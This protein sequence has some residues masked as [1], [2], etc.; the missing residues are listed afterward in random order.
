MNNFKIR[1]KA[2]NQTTGS[3]SGKP[4]KNRLQTGNQTTRILPGKSAKDSQYLKRIKKEIENQPDHPRNMGIA[5]QAHHVISGEGMKRSQLGPTV[6][7]YGYNINLLPNVAFIPCT[8]QGACYLGVQPHRGNHASK[9]VDQD[10]YIDSG[11]E[12]DYHDM[13]ASDL[14]RVIDKH[15]R[16]CTGDDNTVA[17][18]GIAVLDKL[19][20]SILKGIQHDPNNYPLTS[21]ASHF[22]KYGAGCGGVD[23]VTGHIP[24]MPCPVGRNHRVDPTGE[25][26]SHGKEQ[27]LENITF[28]VKSKY[29]LRFETKGILK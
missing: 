21:I 24:L 28:E 13:V 3:A 22:G 29:M 20:K 16:E 7:A 17:H 11:E 19:S 10:D 27:T 23:S 9:V 2:G 26:K 8:L 15:L 4:A 12:K 18:A 1:P 25:R 14:Q 6:K 5:M